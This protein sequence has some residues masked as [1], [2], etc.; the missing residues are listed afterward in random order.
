MF[1]A[2]RGSRVPRA[3]P[4]FAPPPMNWTGGVGG[5]ATSALQY[6]MASRKTSMDDPDMGDWG[7][8]YDALGSLIVQTDARG[9]QIHFGYD[10]G[11]RLLSKTYSGPGACATTPLATY[12]QH[13]GYDETGR[14]ELRVLGNDILRLDYTHYAWTAE[15]GQGRLLQIQA[16]TP[17]D[18]DSLQD[19]RY[20]YDLVGNVDTIEDW[21]AGGPQLQEY[22]YDALDRLSSASVTRG[23]E[24]RYSET[25]SYDATTGNLASKGG[26]AYGYNDGD[27]AHA[28]THLDGVQRF[29][30]DA[31]GNQTAR[32]VGANSDVLTFAAENR[33]IQV[34]RGGNVIEQYLYDGDGHLV[35]KVQGGE[36]TVY[37]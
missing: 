31:N 8:E 4:P 1:G 15:G 7:Y 11:G 27:H 6:D 26:V 20:T 28:V 30:Y 32:N 35:R 12:I 24:G 16:G 29:T 22:G 36:T 13:T 33:L 5:G 14:S 3:G 2:G 9:C 19:L 23:K 37:I 25:Y 17:A 34:S 10:D 21:K 18:P